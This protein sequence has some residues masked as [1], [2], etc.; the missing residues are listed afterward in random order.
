MDAVGKAAQRTAARRS[1]PRIESFDLVLPD[2]GGESPR[3]PDGCGYLRCGAEQHAHQ[4]ALALVELGLL[5]QDQPCRLPA[6]RHPHGR[7]ATRGSFWSEIPAAPGCPQADNAGLASEAL[8]AQL[9][10]QPS[11]VVAAFL[12]ASLQVLLVAVDELRTGWL[13]IRRRLTRPQPAL[14]SLV[15]QAQLVSDALERE[16]SLPQPGNLL[17]ARVA[18]LKP[19]AGALFGS[20]QGHRLRG[21]RRYRHLGHGGLDGLA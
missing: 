8:I 9:P 18:L 14:H 13:A 6:G 5:G 11:C 21:R 17:I 3:Q 16:S 10:P 19:V 20:G 1:D 4:L 2:E 15:A 12:P 7:A